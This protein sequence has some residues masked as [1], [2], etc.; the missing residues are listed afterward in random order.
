MWT[1]W[2]DL[3]YSLRLLAKHPGFTL[4][5]VG[6]LTLGI[7][8]NAGI[9]GIVNGL[10]LRPLAGAD[11]PGE[12]V[13]VYSK[14]RTAT[15]GYRAFSYPGFEDLR[16]A[17]GPFAHLAAHNVSIAGITAGGATRQ[18][19]VDIVSTGYFDALGVRLVHGRD[20]TPDEER[21]GTPA[22]P[23][24]V[25]F[26][27]WERRDFDRD[28]LS[29][30]VRVNG[31]DYTVVGVA[32]EGFGGTTAIIG[33]EFW[34]PLGV[35]DLIE[36]DFDGRDNYSLNDRRNRS[37]IVVG[38]LRPEVSREQA[39]QQLKV[40][41]TAHEAAFPVEN[42]DQDL[43]V[44]PLGRLGVSTSPQED[45]Q[46]WFP[47]VMLQGLAAAVLLTSCLNLANMMLA[48]GSTRQKEIAIRLAV[49]GARARIV[50]Q[51]LVQGLLL[52]LSGGAL[53]VTVSSWGANLL[54]SEVTTIL[55]MSLLLDVSPDLRVVA[56]TFA[57]CTLATLA[58]GL[59]P[60][61]RLSRPD[62]LS[63]LKDQAGEVSGK[64]GRRI[65]VRG[66][67][68]TAQL[69]LSLALLILSGL[70]VRGAAA[71]ASADPGFALEPLLVAETDPR[72]GGFDVAQ[73]K[74]IRR[75]VLERVRSLA[76]VERASAGS[77]IPFG[78]FTV[79]SLVQR[80]GPRLRYDDPEARGKL[81]SALEYVV[82]ADYFSTL[83]LTLRRGRDFTPAEES[84]VGAVT[85]VIIDEALASKLFPNEDPMGQALQFG[86]E[87]TRL[88][89]RP[90]QIVG[91]APTIEHDLFDSAPE[92]HIYL[93]FGATDI[94]RMFI[95]A[96]LSAPSQID[97]MTATM[98][99]EL[100][101]I[102]ANLPVMRL[103][104]FKSQHERSAQVW[105]L[106]AAAR[107]FL[108]LGLAAAFVAVVGLYGVRSYLVTRRTREFGVRMA[109]GASPADVVR[110]VLKEA[111]TTT[112]AG[113]AIGLGLGLL[114]GWGMS[115][116]IYQVSPFDPITLGGAAG[117]LALSSFVASM[118]PARRA[119]NVLP[120]TALRND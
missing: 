19:I 78:D 3:R 60:A 97:A 54:L 64:I 37:L 95:Y 47:V 63:S 14:D 88:G 25:S 94:T 113:L 115:A 110:L 82:G 76:G 12:L 31:D 15:R 44:R 75:R 21:P 84:G 48:F 58:F 4:T 42:K 33:T 92:A 35:H 77:I 8:V 108:T 20:F 81:I 79:T 99:E 24:I 30:L 96:R 100:R 104:S 17:D 49:G 57:F 71:G 112:S 65:T 5:A 109:V 10:L 13:G 102:E 72:L 89:G 9:F 67:L 74:E 116:V 119:A 22:R 50:R 38:R 93:P 59:W 105:I 55:P 1:L 70:F 61:L 107:L 6:V 7:G 73:S 87:V 36:S 114:L 85:P 90:M 106:N 28:I 16:S 120:M 34:L 62:L 23:I 2:Q 68:V 66:A 40:I 51:L 98:R 83:G 69:A 39:D 91:V 46:L 52:S 26:K 43:L 11:A 53:G 29:R 41:A 27:H 18:S 45:S 111:L 56:V 80:E 103:A 117:I 118:V 32:P 86:A 101:A